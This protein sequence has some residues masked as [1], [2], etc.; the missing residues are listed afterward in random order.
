MTFRA[1]VGDFRFIFDHV[2]GFSRVSGTGMF[3][4]AT[5]DV[6]TQIL[7]EAARLADDVLA[8]L[9]R[10]GDEEPAR[11]ENGVVRTTPGFA[12]AYRAIAEGGWIAISAPVEYGGMGL[13]QT[14]TCAVNEMMAGACLS[15][16]LNPLMTQGQIEALEH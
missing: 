13:P 3:A 8:P 1:P 16:Q 14:I 5:D 10:R 11:L 15:L 2:V 9:Q 7:S 12:E 6:A 4:D